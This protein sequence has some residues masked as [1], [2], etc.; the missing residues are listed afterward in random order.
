MSI[1]KEY[2]IGEICYDKQGFIP[3]IAQDY[4][5]GEVLLFAK[6]NEEAVQKTFE[7]EVVYYCDDDGKVKKFGVENGNTQKLIVAFLDDQGK[8]LL[9]KVHQK[10]K[11]SAETHNFSQFHNQIK[12][13][14]KE[15]GGEMF[16]HSNRNF[17]SCFRPRLMRDFTVPRSS[18]RISAIS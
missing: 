10:G 6:M 17:R 4:E 13:E 18:D 5:S 11:A 2:S 8:T 7:T 3:V 16:P 12:G 1:K 14:Y 9:I 15:I